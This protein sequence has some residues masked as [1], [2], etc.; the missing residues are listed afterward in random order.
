ML[1][2][3]VND[4]ALALNVFYDEEDRFFR[5]LYCLPPDSRWYEIVPPP[6]EDTQIML[7]LLRGEVQSDGTICYKSDREWK[8]AWLSIRSPREICL[9]FSET[10]PKLLDKARGDRPGDPGTKL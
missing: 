7:D 1:R 9:Y 6:E 8:K 2:N 3:C 10:R 5:V 4:C